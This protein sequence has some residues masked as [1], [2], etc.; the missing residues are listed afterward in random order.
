M[1]DI[2]ATIIKESLSSEIKYVVLQLFANDKGIIHE[3]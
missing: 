2:E 3:I 1:V